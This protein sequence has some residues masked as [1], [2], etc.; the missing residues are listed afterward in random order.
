MKKM[1]IGVRMLLGLGFVVFGADG[2]MRAITGQGFFPEPTNLSP[3][4]VTVMTGLMG[5]KYL[6]P[7]AKGIEFVAGLTFLL[8]RYV[9]LGIVLLTPV[10]VNILGINLF[11]A[12]E[13]APMAI[14]LSIMLVIV[15][16]DRW[17]Y[18]RPLVV[19]NR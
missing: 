4:L 3:E 18:F 5:M 12:P 16:W 2:L 6:F 9:N 1:I 14:A 13:G 19:T 15:I 7:L 8:G 10:M 17:A 11:V